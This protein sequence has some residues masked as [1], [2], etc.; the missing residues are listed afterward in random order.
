VFAA[1]VP[2]FV[3]ATRFTFNDGRQDWAG[4]LDSF[5]VLYNGPELATAPE[6]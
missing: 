6:P 2:D 3:T 1:L 5:N 4:L